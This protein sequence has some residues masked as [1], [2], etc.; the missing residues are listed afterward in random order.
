MEKKTKLIKGAP[1]L[2]LEGGRD[3]LGTWY[4]VFPSFHDPIWYFLGMFT[5]KCVL[6][7]CRH[8]CDDVRGCLMIT[9]EPGF[10]LP[11]TINLFKVPSIGIKCPP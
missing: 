4:H 9:P 10:L 3:F 6:L 11:P 1:F 8:A 7:A 2:F 5:C